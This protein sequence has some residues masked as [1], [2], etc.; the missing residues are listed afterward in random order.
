M[1]KKNKNWWILTFA[2]SQSKNMKEQY[3]KRLEQRVSAVVMWLEHKR[4]SIRAE[5]DMNRR[6][7]RSRKDNF[8]KN[9][10]LRGNNSIP[11][12]LVLKNIQE[13]KVYSSRII[14]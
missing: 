3:K 6:K 11:W 12:T 8:S 13:P 7:T 5:T 14:H 2:S 1:E 10:T 4:R 9:T